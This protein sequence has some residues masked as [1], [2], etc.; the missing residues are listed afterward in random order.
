MV[1]RY[2]IIPI[3]GTSSKFFALFPWFGGM[4][5]LPSRVPGIAVRKGQPKRTRSEEWTM[6]LTE[7]AARREELITYTDLLAKVIIYEQ[8]Q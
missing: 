5:L 4:G 8:T 3:L 1:Q 2:K 6:S 7:L